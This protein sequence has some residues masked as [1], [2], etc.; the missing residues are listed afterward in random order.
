MLSSAIKTAIS[1]QGNAVAHFNLERRKS[2]MKHLNKDLQPLAK[3][4]FPDRGPWLF[5]EGFDTKAKTMSDNIKALKSTLGKRKAPFSGSGGPSRKR[6]FPTK[7]PRAAA[8][9]FA[10]SL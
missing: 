7:S 5:G 1:L 6:K 4:S 9:T 10:H 3:G 2:I 8:C